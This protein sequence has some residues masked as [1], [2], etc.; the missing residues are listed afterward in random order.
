MARFGAWYWLF[1]SWLLVL[2]TWIKDLAWTIHFFFGAYLRFGFEKC[3]E[4]KETVMYLLV[5]LFV[6]VRFLGQCGLDF[7]DVLC[8]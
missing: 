8:C 4:K 5:G 7:L 6:V 2:K 3:C 1:M